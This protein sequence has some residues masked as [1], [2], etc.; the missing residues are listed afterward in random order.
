MTPTQAF[1]KAKKYFVRVIGSDYY[2]NLEITKS[3]A[4]FVYSHEHQF[5]IDYEAKTDELFLFRGSNLPG[6][7][8]VKVI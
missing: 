6:E 5:L 8:I 3:Q 2:I 1:R 4:Q 7:R